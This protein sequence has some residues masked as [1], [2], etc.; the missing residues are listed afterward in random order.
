M[1]PV[2]YRNSDLQPVVIRSLADAEKALR[3]HRW[4]RTETYEKALHTVQECLA[5]HCTPKC[6]LAAF[7]TLVKEQGV[8]A[9]R[10]AGKGLQ[11]VDTLISDF[12]RMS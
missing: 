4:R 7:I 8:L 12:R 2:H 3:L 11:G 1:E 10:P 9:P 6:A 5:G